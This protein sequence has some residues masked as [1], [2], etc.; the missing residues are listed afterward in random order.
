MFFSLRVS[1]DI[2]SLLNSTEYF[3]TFNFSRNCMYQI[4]A[5]RVSETYAT[6][7]DDF[8]IT[9]DFSCQLL[10]AFSSLSIVLP[11]YA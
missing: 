7:F 8:V 3:Q 2:R 6:Y 4:V 11:R 1:E 10:L 5:Y 9:F